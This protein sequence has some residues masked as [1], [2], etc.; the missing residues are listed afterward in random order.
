MTQ[1]EILLA[2]KASLAEKL[3]ERHV[4]RSLVNP[5]TEKDTRL[6]D[7][8]VC[9]VATGGGN[10]ANWQGREG[11]LGTINVTLV[12][13]VKV[14]DKSL[15]EAVEAAELALL[16]DLLGWCQD[17]KDEPLDSVYPMTWETSKQL[18]HPVGYLVLNIEVK[19]T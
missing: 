3:P 5:A 15:P 9:V 17:I 18:A 8:V 14:S 11:E 6:L 16:S 4:Q 10:F 7:G 12:A 2:V 1:D 13:Y 19:Y